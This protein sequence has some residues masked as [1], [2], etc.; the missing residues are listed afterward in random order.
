M[1][2]LV[3]RI[4]RVRCAE[5]STFFRSLDDDDKA[6]TVSLAQPQPRYRAHLRFFPKRFQ[7]AV[8][9]NFRFVLLFF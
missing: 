3:D 6:T 9:H 5:T 2:F 4:L 8:K 1:D 7:K